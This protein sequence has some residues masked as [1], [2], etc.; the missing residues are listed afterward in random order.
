MSAC[1]S[2]EVPLH[3]A[4]HQQM[5]NRV[6][7]RLAAIPK[8]FDEGIATGFEGNG[9]R[10]DSNP[11][12]VNTRYAR[13]AMRLAPDV[14]WAS[15]VARDDAFTADVL[16]GDAYTLAW[17]IH[18]MLATQH[19]DKYT[20]Y[21]EDLAKRPPLEEVG[22]EERVEHFESTFG[23]SIADIHTQFPVAV[24]TAAR[25]QKVNLA[26]APQTT[27]ANEQQA[28]GQFSIKATQ[29]LDRGG[30]LQVAGMLKNISPLRALTFYVTVETEGGVYADWVA[31][32]VKPNQQIN[33]P[34]QMA[35]KH[36]PGVRRGPSDSYRVFVRSAPADSREASE[37]KSGQVPGPISGER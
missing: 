31:A 37:W 5:Y 17:C 22:A 33:L 30:Q 7:Q 28:L 4:I 26:D 34:S 1:D 19:K 27:I 3:E 2:F 35:H 8:W 29:L 24:Q 32:D 21:V 13:L 20:K 11:A 25:R 15:V 10:I 16:V 12:K 9:E 6:F 18:W 23:V 14:R 36:I